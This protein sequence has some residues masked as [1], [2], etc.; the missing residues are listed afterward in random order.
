MTMRFN[1]ANEAI[2]FRLWQYAEQIG[3]N[4]TIAEAADAIDE[5]MNRV[6]GIVGSKGWGHRFRATRPDTAADFRLEA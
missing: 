4:C 2:A 5:P 3:W 1:P 6:R